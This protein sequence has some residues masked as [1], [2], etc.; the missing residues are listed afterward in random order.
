V[1]QVAEFTTEIIPSARIVPGMWGR[2]SSPDE[3]RLSGRLRL[4]ARR[5]SS[6]CRR[7]K[8]CSQA[9]QV[10]YDSVR[11]A[12]G[13]YPHVL[14]LGFHLLRG[15][16]RISWHSPGNENRQYYRASTRRIHP[17]VNSIRSDIP[18]LTGPP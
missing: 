10:S 8:L 15:T 9:I 4:P 3:L 6:P 16:H 7:Q 5:N 18:G 11:G 17:P 14:L 13:Q 1:G 12:R 2:V